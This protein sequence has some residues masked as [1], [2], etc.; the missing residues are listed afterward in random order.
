MGDYDKYSFFW[1]AS[2]GLTG[3]AKRYCKPSMPE[4]QF[5]TKTDAGSLVSEKRVVF[6]ATHLLDSLYICGHCL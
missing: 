3:L 6:S 1:V 4:T 2:P 5:P